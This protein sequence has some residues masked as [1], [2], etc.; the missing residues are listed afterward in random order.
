MGNNVT[1]SG[2]QCY[3]QWATMLQS[4]GHNVTIS[5]A[6]CY[7]Q[8]ATMLQSVSDLLDMPA[9]DHASITFTLLRVVCVELLN[10]RS[11]LLDDYFLKVSVD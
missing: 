5:G 8:W 2:P 11:Q 1:I 9:V 3:N 10:C 4:V 7:N 6:Q